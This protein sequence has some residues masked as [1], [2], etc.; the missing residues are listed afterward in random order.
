MCV[1]S[2]YCNVMNRAE[3]VGAP[4]DHVIAHYPA[5]FRI[6]LRVGHCCNYVCQS[7]DLNAASA[8]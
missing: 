3:S 2:R 5:P 6:E 8:R 7:A 4:L 1:D